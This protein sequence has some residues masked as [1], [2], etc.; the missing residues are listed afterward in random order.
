MHDLPPSVC[1]TTASRRQHPRDSAATRRVG[2]HALRQIVACLLFALTTVVGARAD[3]RQQADPRKIDTGLPIPDESYC[4]QPYVVVLPSGKWLC[5]LTT[6]PGREGQGGQHVVSTTSDDHGKTWSPLVDIE[7][8]AGPYASWAVPL[9]TPTGRVYAFYTY[10]GDQIKHLPGQSK[11]IRAD[12]LGWYCYKFSDDEGRSWSKQ[13][14][15]LPMRVTACDRGN[16]W[17]GQV[18]LFWG[19]D[20][21]KVSGNGIRFA[22]TKLG[23]FPLD[24][25]EGWMFHSPNIL[26]QRQPDKIEWKLMPTGDHGIRLPRFGSIQEE[27]NHV[28]LAGDDLYLVYRTALG[29]PCHSYSRDGGKTWNAPE[30]MTYGPRG[31]VIKNPRACPKLWK[32]ANGK[33]LFWFHNHGGTSFQGRN[34]AWI[35]G[36]ELRDGKLYW[37]QPEILLYADESNERMSYPDLIEQDGRY[38]ITETQKTMAR[39]HEIDPTLLEGLW[40]QGK[41]AV[42]VTKG[43]VLDTTS[44]DATLPLQL[45]LTQTGGLSLDCWFTAGDPAR[46]HTLADSRNDTGRGFL[47][48]TTSAGTI[49]LELSDGTHSASWESDSGLLKPGSRHHVVAIVDAAP[50]IIMFVVDGRLCDGGDSRQRGWTR[51]TKSIDDIAGKMKPSIGSAVERLRVYNRY[52]RVSEAV[53]NY[54]AGVS[55]KTTRSVDPASTS[56]L[57]YYAQGGVVVDGVAYFTANDA[58]RRPGVTRTANFPSVVAFD[59]STFK[60]LRSY[61][62]QATYDSSPLVVQRRDGT[63]LVIA[64]EHK[65]ARTV[66]LHRDTGEPVWV[67]RPNQPGS[68]FFGYS[69]YERPD[70]SKIILIAATNGLHAICGETGKEL[71]WI[72]RTSSGGVT[73]CVDQQRGVTYYQANGTLLKVRVTDGTVLKEVAVPTPSRCISWNTV[74]IDDQHGRYVATRWYGKPEWDSAIRVYDPD[75]NLAWEKIG[76]PIG[77]KDTLTYVDGKIISGSGNS[78]SKKYSGDKWKYI[79]AYAIKDGTVLWKCDL[80]K[81]DYSD[82]L[83]VPHFNGYLYAE[84]G[85]FPTTTA[86]CFRID[87]RNGKLKEVFDYGRPITSCATHIIARGLLLS[88]DLWNDSIVVTRLAHNA[89]ADWPGP[90]GDPQTN[91]MSAPPDPTAKLTPLEEVGHDPD[92]LKSIIKVLQSQSSKSKQVKKRIDLVSNRL[93]LIEESQR[94]EKRLA[95][96][97]AETRTFRSLGAPQWALAQRDAMARLRTWTYYWIDHQRPDGQFGG[98]YEDDVELVCGWPVLVLGQDDRR[99]FDSLARLADGVWKS[100][101]FIERYGYGPFTDVEHAAETVSYSQPRMVLLDY[102]D[103]KWAE[104]CRRSVET[105]RREFLIYNNVT[106][107]MSLPSDYFGIDPKTEKPR[108]RR[109]DRPFDIPEGAKAL[110]PAMYAAW[111]LDDGFSA[112]TMLLYGNGW[113]RASHISRKGGGIQGML[114]HRVDPRYAIGSG[115][116]GRISSMRALLFHLIGCYERSHDDKYLDPIRT[117]LTK[118]VVEWSAGDMPWVDAVHR[119]AWLIDTPQLTEEEF[120]RVNDVDFTGLFDQLALVAILYREAIGDTQFDEHLVRWANRVRT[121]L[122]DGKKSYVMLGRKRKGLWYVNRPLT[123]GAYR[124]S[125]CAVG[126]Q[127]YMGWRF[128]GDEDYLAKL[129]WNLSSCLNDRWGAFTYWFYDQSERRVTSNDHLAHKIQTS[130]AALCLMYTGGAA[131]IEAVWP[132]LAVSWKDVGTNFCAL[133]RNHD[134]SS[135][136]VD[137][138]TFDKQPR[139]ITARFWELAPGNYEIVLGPD[140]DRNQEIDQ[141]RQ[142]IPFTVSKQTEPVAPV[143]VTFE[144]PAQELTLLQV[145]RRHPGGQ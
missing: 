132:K 43:V 25:G 13:R 92:R 75:L 66:A 67:S 55:R 44:E 11:K 28:A 18:Q 31:R 26:T 123:V 73:P 24:E 4:D 101:P 27:H 50:Q 89:T 112:G 88:G 121:S 6:G 22:F 105:L 51:Y 125:R 77:K 71:W 81:H 15:R 70:Q 95:E 16:E 115:T 69:Y 30:P 102:G 76:L 141:T 107:H 126:A 21:P 19:I 8:A 9:V 59:L 133:V 3:N 122:V 62:F 65:Q 36:G 48:S 57:D 113:V 93:R 136:N 52:L 99:V 145:R 60:K 80:S 140:A 56:G 134:S 111:R 29:F 53:A 40:N 114:P 49:R 7:P 117:L 5:T 100:R 96:I 94:Y 97:S 64:H 135:L 120:R 86:K 109:S 39:V 46:T 128:T 90:F 83:N 20:K 10:N 54:R 68:L 129:G 106:N 17:K 37:S 118:A 79:A 1:N 47:L 45:D 98:G 131:P 42:A 85:G 144:L 138:F 35:S 12:V 33:Y 38:W 116:H 58:S 91:Q 72:K 61:K 130:Q 103:R 139:R 14:Y 87:V 78:W 41:S 127:L 34:P 82:I 74:L 143:S 32:C 104:R 124:E 63:W 2:L 119:T 23:R 137:L 108:T 110:K 142:T 84:N